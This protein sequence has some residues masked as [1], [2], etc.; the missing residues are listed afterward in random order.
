MSFILDALKKSENERARHSGPALLELRVVPRRRSVPWWAVAVGVVLLANLVVLSIVLLRRTP[1]PAPPVA[2]Q[3]APPP[4][5][6]AATAA[7]QATLPA[8][9]PL[10]PPVAAAPAEAAPYVPPAAVQPVL[11]AGVNPADYQPARPPSTVMPELPPDPADATLPT[12]AD[13]IAAGT[14][15]PEQHLALHVYDENP[16]GRFV[17]LN[18]QRLREGESAIDGV[19]IER[20]TPD[21]AVASWRGR[22]FRLMP[23]G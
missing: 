18:S 4:P 13:L 14:G 1:E 12:A 8:P 10:P 20:I 5:P 19:R 21:G 6:A 9:A 15:L 22:R 2:Q 7:P 17:L 23:G 16:A 11:P 3:V